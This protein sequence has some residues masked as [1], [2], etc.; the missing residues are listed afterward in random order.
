MK[1]PYALIFLMTFLGLIAGWGAGS[2]LSNAG[3]KATLA[4]L[5][6][7]PVVIASDYD[8]KSKTLALPFSNPGGQP[9]TLLGKAVAFKPKSGQGYEI[10]YVDFEKPVVVPAFSVATLAVKMKAKTPDLV[11]GDVV[12]TTIRYRYPLLPDVYD[13]THVFTHGQ[14]A[15]APEALKK[16]GNGK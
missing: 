2:Y 6:A 8:Q 7:A 11:D 10:A 16:S 4:T 14:P 5:P 1:R 13:M 9:V 12:A 3:L 15:E